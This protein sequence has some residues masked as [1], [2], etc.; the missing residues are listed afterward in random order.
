MSTCNPSIPTLREQAGRTNC[1]KAHRPASLEHTPRH[2]TAAETRDP[3][4]ERWKVR[5]NSQKL[6][7]DFHKC[8]PSSADIHTKYIKSNKEENT[9]P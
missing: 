4:P 8:V 7:S 2:N 5:T 9:L 6:S 1:L 3:A